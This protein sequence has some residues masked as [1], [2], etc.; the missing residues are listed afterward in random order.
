MDRVQSG[1]L[2]WTKLDDL[3]RMILDRILPDFGLEGLP[4]EDKR[5]L[6]FVWH[7]LN[8]WP[9]A[10]S[11][12]LRLKS[13]Y[14]I[15]PLSN[16]NLALLTDLAKFGGLPWDCILASDVF[17]RYKPDPE[18]YL[19]AA[20]ILGIEPSQLMMVA[21]HVNDLN[22]ARKLGLRTGFVHRP[23]ERGPGAFI[24]RPPA[25]AYDVVASDIRDLASQLGL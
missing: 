14:V 13:R 6:N 1:E 11:G 9:D 24:Q 23:H 2:P 19:G 18:M 5:Y 17:R 15:S 10:P 21:A 3:H 25:D 22:A 4:E 8:A 20:L 7:R 16:G 12:L